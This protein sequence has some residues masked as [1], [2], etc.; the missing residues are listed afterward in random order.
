LEEEESAGLFLLFFL[1]V[2]AV[3][4]RDMEWNAT[5]VAGCRPAD[6]ERVNADELKS[7]VVDGMDIVRMIEGTRTGRRGPDIPDMD[8]VISLCGEM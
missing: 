2:V 8:V 7:Q 1:V 5:N 4:L 6:V 3:A